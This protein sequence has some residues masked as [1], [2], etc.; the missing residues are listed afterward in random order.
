MYRALSQ[1]E[2]GTQGL[3]NRLRVRESLGYVR[4]KH[5]DVR[6][7]F[8]ASRVLAADHWPKSARRYSGRKWSEI[9]LAFFIRYILL[10]RAASHN[11]L[12]QC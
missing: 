6:G 3:I 4:V 8:H 2:Q 11:H 10:H 1:L 12:R 7:F 9:V 5:D